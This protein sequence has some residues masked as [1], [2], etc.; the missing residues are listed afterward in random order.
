MMRQAVEKC[1]RRAVISLRGIA[2]NARD[3][4]EHDKAIEFHFSRCFVKQPCAVRLW[5]EN[6]SHAFGRERGER[7]IV[8]HHRE[9]KNTAQRL[10]AGFDLRE[11]SLHVVRRADIR[12]TPRA[13]P[14]RAP[15]GLPR[16]LRPPDS[17]RRCGS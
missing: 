10:S 16:I 8:D 4:G 3:R 9:M 5:S 13:L 11:K 1:I 2:E 7:R 12:R 15:A 6:G 14:H 17:K